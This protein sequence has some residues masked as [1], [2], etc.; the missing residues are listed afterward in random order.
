M[1]IVETIAKIRRYH[2]V[3]GKGIK[4]ISRKLGVSRNT[5]RKVVRSGSTEHQ[6]N[7]NNQPMPRLGDYVERLEKLLEDDWQQPKKRRYTAQRLYDLL[8]TEG[9]SG[10]YDSIQRFTKQWREKKGKD[11]GNAF[12]PL[13]FEPGDAFQFDWSHELVV[14]G[15]ATVKIN[16]AHFRLCHSRFFFVVAYLRESTEMVFDAHSQAFSFFGGVCK[17]GI[18]DNMSTAVSKVLQGKERIFNRRFVQLCSHYL[19]EPVACTPAA[20]WEKGQVEKQVKNVR[21]WLFTPR[22]RFENLEELNCW[23]R[24]QCIAISKKRNHPEDKERTIWEL[25]QEEQASLIQIT[26]PF[27]GYAEK[28]CR[29]TSTSLVNYDRNQYSVNSKIAGKTATI[30]AT[31]DLIQV[32]KDGEVVGEHLRRFGRGKTI[33]DPWHYLG[34][35]ERKPGGLR[36]GAPFKNWNL[37]A[38]LLRVQ[39]RLLSRPGGDREFVK[40][41]NGVQIYGLDTAEQACKK[42]LADA[43]IRSEVVLNLMARELDPPPIDPVNTPDSLTLT[44]EPLANCS[45]YDALRQEVHHAAP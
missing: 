14:L 29:V 37:P 10:S 18:Y 33:Y 4:E 31:A 9:Y 20:G 2:F 11:P 28:E 17:R 39:Q 26:A 35:L 3:H 32:I 5:V 36:D 34:I 43:T 8:Q 38:P 21:E 19:L 1:L 40:I 30:R 12:I 25:F 7:R 23:L 24:G 15:G 42:A 44:E 13:R 45:R 6:Y 41:L 22:P 16:V 27:D